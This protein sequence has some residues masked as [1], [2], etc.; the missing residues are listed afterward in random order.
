MNL[1]IRFQDGQTALHAA[2]VAGHIDAVTALTLNGAD[3]NAQD[4]VSSFLSGK[5]N[6]L[7]CPEE[8]VKG[9]IFSISST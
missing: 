5:L 9:S 3:A 2:A 7:L 1:S 8:V 4:F 6:V